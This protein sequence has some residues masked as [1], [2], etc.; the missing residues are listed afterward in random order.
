M[1]QKQQEKPSP[2]SLMGTRISH[3]RFLK[4]S[5]LLGGSA[6]VASQLGW[7]VGVMGRV[8]AGPAGATGYDYDIQL[9]ENTIYSTC[10]QCHVACPIKGE[11]AAGILGKLDGNPYSPQQ[12]LPHLEYATSPFEAALTGGKICSK[13]QSAIQTMYDPY[14][15]VKVLKRDGP[16]GSNKWRTITFEQAVR[17]IVEGENLF[18]EGHVDGLD[19]VLALRNPA[20]AKALADDVAKIKKGVLSVDQFKANHA[21]HLHTLID[22]DHPDKGPKNNQYTSLIGRAE[23]GRKEFIKRFTSTCTSS[24]GSARSYLTTV[25]VGRSIQSRRCRPA[26]RSTP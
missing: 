5:A 14:R 10:L 2:A 24:P 8:A 21:D 1:T 15:L 12:M 18:G 13:G 9:P 26:R 4:T 25:L 19:A 20:A 3:R 16:R 22:P 7:A 11:L 23:H 17:E 6:V